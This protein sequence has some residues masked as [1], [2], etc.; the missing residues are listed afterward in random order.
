MRL[1]DGLGS[2]VNRDA[3]ENCIGEGLSVILEHHLQGNVV[4]IFRV[5]VELRLN[6]LS[7]RNF[8]FLCE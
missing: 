2:I 3:D 6:R 4:E 5:N 7:G 1:G 8:D